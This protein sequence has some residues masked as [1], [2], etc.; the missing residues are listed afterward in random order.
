MTGRNK[1]KKYRRILTCLS[2]SFKVFGQRGNVFLLSFFRNT[3]GILG[4]VLRYILVKNIAKKVGDNVSIQPNVFLFNLQNVE[5]GNNVSIHPMCYIEGAGGITI[6]NNVSIAHSS[7]LIST[8]HI[9][10]DINT[11]IKYNK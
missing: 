10:E 3:N 4:I 7:T 9:W 8:N 5:I 1:F 2:Y 6:G 11:P